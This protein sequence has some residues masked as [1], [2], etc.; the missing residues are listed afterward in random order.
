MA[1]SRNAQNPTLVPWQATPTPSSSGTHPAP[2]HPRT[3]IF[4]SR[5][6]PAPAVGGYRWEPRASSTSPRHVLH[7]LNV[8]GPIRRRPASLKRRAN[9]GARQ[10]TISADANIAILASQHNSPTVGSLCGPAGAGVFRAIVQRHTC[11]CVGRA[12]TPGLSGAPQCTHRIS[13]RML[14]W[15]VVRTSSRTQQQWVP[16]PTELSL[17]AWHVNFTYT[18]SLIRQQWRRRRTA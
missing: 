4:L 10:S 14:A 13:S 9:Y 1:I 18:V 5:R 17:R 3:H 7:A 6:T 12:R 16:F 11:M 15:L 8:Q 2:P